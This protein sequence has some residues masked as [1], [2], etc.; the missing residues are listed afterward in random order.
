MVTINF[1]TYNCKE[2]LSFHFY[3]FNW[4]NAFEWV[5]RDYCNIT[6][7]RK[8]YQVCVSLLTAV[9]TNFIFEW[10]YSL[11]DFVNQEIG[12]FT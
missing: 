12:D 3:I 4:G 6:H 2:L 9:Q 1:S 7:T 8:Q 10:Y 5:S 11:S